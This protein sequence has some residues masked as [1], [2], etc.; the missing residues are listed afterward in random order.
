MAVKEQAKHTPG[1][2]RFARME[3]AEKLAV[4]Q[5]RDLAEH[6]GYFRENNGDW[7]VGYKNEHGQGRI[8]GVSFKGTAKRGQGYM[9]PDPPI[10]L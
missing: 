7:I 4:L 9:A 8:A 2:W 5:H 3:D 1:P 10:S 6:E